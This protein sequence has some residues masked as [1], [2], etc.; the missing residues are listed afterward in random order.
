MQ[1]SDGKDTLATYSMQV[2]CRRC[3]SRLSGNP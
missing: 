2:Q 1:V 3:H